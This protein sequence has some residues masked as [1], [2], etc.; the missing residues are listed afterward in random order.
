LPARAA[1]AS[2]TRIAPGAA[3]AAIRAARITTVPKTSSSAATTSPASIPIRDRRGWRLAAARLGLHD[4]A[5]RRHDVPGG[6]ED[7]H[8]AVAQRLDQV[9]AAGLHVPAH[10]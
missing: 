8:L 4:A 3:D 10:Q 5:R 6:S 2:D 9:A 7:R 1:T